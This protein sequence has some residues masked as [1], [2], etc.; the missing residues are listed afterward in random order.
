M[1]LCSAVTP[2]LR[3]TQVLTITWRA[4]LLL[5]TLPF[6]FPFC[7]VL[8]CCYNR[9]MYF[10]TK[11]EKQIERGKKKKDT[12]KNTTKE[13]N[14]NDEK[15]KEEKRIDGIRKKTEEEKKSS[16]Q[17]KTRRKRSVAVVSTTL[18]VYLSHAFHPRREWALQ[19]SSGEFRW[20]FFTAHKHEMRS[21]FLFSSSSRRAPLLPSWGL[22]HVPVT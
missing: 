21:F 6:S 9:Y 22:E 12:G 18:S 16:K 19:S 7:F 5:S 2:L 17:T 8:F 20:A 15:K 11:K 14:K 10:H 3:P 1:L 13:K 4:R